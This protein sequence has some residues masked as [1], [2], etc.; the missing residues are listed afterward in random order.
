MGR[1]YIFN[2]C[3]CSFYQDLLRKLDCLVFDVGLLGLDGL[4]SGFETGLVGVVWGG[5]G[6]WGFSTSFISG[7]SWWCWSP[8]AN[9]TDIASLLYF[10]G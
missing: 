1:S 4:G 9:K 3:L 8:K 10:F 7:V 5:T 6:T 2:H